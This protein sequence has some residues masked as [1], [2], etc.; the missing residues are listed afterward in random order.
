MGEHS[1]K[2]RIL[3]FPVSTAVAFS[4]MSAPLR[5]TVTS[6]AFEETAEKATLQL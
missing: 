5:C 2:D 3:R 1:Y 4:K 6:H